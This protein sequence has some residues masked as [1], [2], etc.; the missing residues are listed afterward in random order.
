V[1]SPYERT[2][3]QR[4]AKLL[5]AL[6]ATFLAECECYFGGGTAIALQLGEYRESVDV[7][8]VCASVDGF[9]RLRNTVSDNSLGEL[10]ATA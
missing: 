9:R 3:H 1:S 2:H 6:D 5:S 4:M 7:D 8:V 10:A